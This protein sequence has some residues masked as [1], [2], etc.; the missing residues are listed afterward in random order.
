MSHARQVATHAL[1]LFDATENIHRL[2]DRAR[3]LVEN[4]ALLH[5]VGLQQDEENHDAAGRDIVMATQL[6]GFSQG[7]RAMLACTVAF[8]RRD[9]VPE[10]ETLFNALNEADRPQTLIL[11]AIV[12][13]ADGVDFSQDQSTVIEQIGVD[14]AELTVRLSGPASHAA[15]ARAD[16]KADLWRSVLGPIAIAGRLN[17]PGITPDMPLALAGR[18]MMRYHYDAAPVS[19]WRIQNEPAAWPE[20]RIKKLRAAVRRMR[21]DAQLFEPSFKG[22]AIR[23]I[24]KGLKTLSGFLSEPRELGMMIANLRDYQASCDEDA[25]DALNPLLDAWRA[26]LGNAHE[27]LQAYGASNDYQHWLS[28]LH[29]FLQ[30]SE[31]DDYGRKTDVGE[32]SRVRHVLRSTLWQ[33]I[34]RIAAYDV[35]P[36]APDLDQLHEL[37]GAV[38][39]L[40]IFVDVSRELLPEKQ[41]VQLSAQCR[42]AQDAYGAINDAHVCAQRAMAFVA[43]NRATANI[44]LKAVSRFAEAQKRLIDTHLGTWRPFLKSLLDHNPD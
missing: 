24:A 8:H 6:R 40:G 30:I 34:D 18:R 4:A 31:T 26:E 28:A 41:S 3:V 1:A 9:V 27:K 5:N 17:A 2:A 13:V 36:D 21:F 43:S 15:A 25:R 32:P 12:R 14:D 16:K 35:L 10:M 20:K 42:A 39:K 44:S 23:P 33:H 38:K 37:R 11:S 29:T 7:E 22:K 19:A